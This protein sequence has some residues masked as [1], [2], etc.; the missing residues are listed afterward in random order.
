MP[1]V[2]NLAMP[3][4]P[5]SPNAPAMERGG[6]VRVNAGEALAGLGRI[7][8][9][10]AGMAPVPGVPQN[11]G[12]GAA[13]GMVNLG[14]GVKDLGQA[15]FQIEEEIAKARNYNLLSE[16]ALAMDREIGEFEKFQLENPDPSKWPAE[17]DRR[18]SEWPGRYLEGRDYPPAVKD[19]INS[20]VLSQGQRYGIEVGVA[21]KKQEVAMARDNMTLEFMRA[22][23][24]EEIE[25]LAST[26]EAKLWMDPV[27]LEMTRL[28]AMDR[29]ESEQLDIAKNMVQADI[30]AGKW[31]VAKARAQSVPGLRED[32]R[33][34]WVSG[35]EKQ[36]RQGGFIQQVDQVGYYNPDE[37]LNML[38]ATDENGNWVNWSGMS[39]EVR[40][41]KSREFEAVRADGWAK[42][43]GEIRERISTEGLTEADLEQDPD[44]KK[45]PASLQA[46]TVQSIRKGALDDFM[47][48]SDFEAKARQLDTRSHEGKIKASKMLAE[49]QLR[50]TGDAAESA[51]STVQDAINN[52]KP[53]MPDAE[54]ITMARSSIRERFENQEFGKFR[55]AK[56][57]IVEQE[58]YRDNK[59]TGEMGYFVA[60]PNP[61]EGF[62]FRGRYKSIFG[63]VTMGDSRLRQVQ[64]SPDEVKQFKDPKTKD[65]TLFTDQVFY[66][67]AGRKFIDAVEE[68]ERKKEAGEFK[69]A[70]DYG[71]ELGRI[72][73]V[74]KQEAFERREA[75]RPEPVMRGDL[76]IPSGGGLDTDGA[77]WPPA[78]RNPVDKLNALR[79]ATG[80]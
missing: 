37:A 67:A 74:S 29:L 57:D 35:I 41:K 51:I 39:D 25:A 7:A 6:S 2:P 14:Q 60:D 21:A 59:P 61:P 78:L 52:P 33:I 48:L 30:N 38:N 43:A 54:A 13:Q 11:L 22:G 42:S 80:Y 70:V 3:G 65:D 64:L 28:K 9:N 44:F 40:F 68:V 10:L 12:Q 18:V 16:A 4:S 34:A 32:E 8:D 47:E 31:D 27:T 46:A 72:M 50:F 66:Q 36:E 1:I 17:W 56:T 23:S 63:N 15:R 79:N 19:A 45:L 77:M 71:D 76:E 58:I 26:P 69:E 5:A 24:A 49:A 55:Y 62:G 53:L 20:R 73:G 75:S